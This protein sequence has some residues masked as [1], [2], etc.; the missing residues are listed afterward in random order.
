M[1][2]FLLAL[3][4]AEVVDRILHVV[5]DRILTS[6]DLA[7]EGELAA[8][9]PSPVP[10]LADPAYPI[11]QRLPD[12]AILRALAGE[13][14]VYEPTPA[15]VRAR[16]ERL[17]ASWPVREDYEAFL[18]RWGLDEERL[19][20]LVYSR[21]VVEKYV[22]RNLPLPAEPAD[23]PAWRAAYQPWMAGLRERVPVR[24]P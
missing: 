18:A 11:E 16:G 14:A 9:D 22:M 10:A 2:L 1:W 13:V 19:L 3:A 17:R 4:R 20:G 6:S 24:T 23:L 5:G 8:H 12:M 15:E 7:F 21:L